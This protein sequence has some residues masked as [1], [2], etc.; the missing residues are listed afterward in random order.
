MKRKKEATPNAFVSSKSHLCDSPNKLESGNRVF[1]SEVIRKEFEPF[2]SE[3]FVSLDSNSSSVPIKILRDTGATQSLLLEGVLPLDSGTSTGESIIAH[4]IEGGFVNIPLHKVHLVS[5]LVSG[6]VVVGTR[7]TL[8]IEGVSLLLG[9]DLAGGRVIADPKVSS[10]P[11]TSISTEKL[12]EV[13]PG[14]FPSCAVTRAMSKKTSEE[15]TAFKRSEDDLINLSDTFLN[16][17]ECNNEHPID[18]KNDN[19]EV[20]SENHNLN[21]GLDIPLTK[22]KLVSEQ[23]K[24]DELAPLFELVL[25]QSELDNVPVGYFVKNGVLMRKWRPPLV[26]ASEEWSIVHQIVVPKLYRDDILKLAH[27]SAMGG[28]LG[29]NKTLDRITKH[30]YWPRIRHSVSEFCKTCHVCQM[31]GKPNQKIPVAPLKPIPAF[32]EPFSRIIIDCVGP[33]P[34][35]RSRNQYLLTIM[36]ASTGYPEAI[37]L[38]NTT[39]PK[40]SKAL[41]NF[42]TFV[43]LPKEIQSDQGSNFMSGLF[44]QVVFQL[45]AKQ[46]KSS[47]YH[48]ESQGALERFH[49]T[50]KNMIKTYC[51]DNEKDRDEGIGLLLFA[52]RESV[53][54]SLGFSPFE[55]V[56]GH[57]VRGP[58]KLVKGNW[59]CESPQNLN[60]LD[61]VTKFRGRLKKV[62]EL[63]QTNPRESQFEM[64]NR[65]DRKAQNSTF[66][67]SDTI[68]VLLPVHRKQAFCKMKYLLCSE[69]VLTAPNFSKPFRL[70]VDTSDVGAGAVLLQIDDENI[71][72]PVCYFSKKFNIHQKNYST[73]EKETLALILAVQHFDVYISSSSKPIVVYTDHNP[74][75]FLHKMKNKNRRLLNWSLMLQ[76]Y[77]LQIEHIKGKDNVCADALSRSCITYPNV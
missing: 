28:H 9:N 24:D 49:S 23:E 60:L 8:P 3:G 71:E 15:P 18:N 40:I 11:V 14:I 27:D 74:L 64:K 54:E 72:H 16:S 55:L 33:L 48:P 51:F 44:Q 57:S 12:E 65:Y 25:P 13:I 5:D 63:A 43:G 58:L 46:I 76:E 19:E 61:Y 22:S 39:A 56:F 62:C 45:G 47:A 2:V 70:A 29:I 36:C 1:K 7:P 42:F 77:N 69:P 10:R 21:E 53:Q 26:P 20:I 4:G 38:S 59:L 41:I 67:P 31:V 50:L 66:K 68:L 6:S 17:L 52:V 37:P 34:K 73:V 32:V 35:T 30:F 75:V